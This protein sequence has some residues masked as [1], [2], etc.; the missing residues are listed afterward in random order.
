[1]NMDNLMNMEYYNFYVLV[2]KF[3]LN[4]EKCDF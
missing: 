4:L 2:N 3:N 1:M